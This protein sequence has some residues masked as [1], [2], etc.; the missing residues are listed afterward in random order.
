MRLIQDHAADPTVYSSIPGRE[1]TTA[2]TRGLRER[3]NE[4]VAF[5]GSFAELLGS[6]PVEFPRFWTGAKSDIDVILLAIAAVK[7]SRYCRKSLSGNE[8]STAAGSL[9]PPSTTRLV[10]SSSRG[11]I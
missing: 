3:C 4:D 1:Q 11:R 5:I 6:S 2:W 9:C 7:A 10:A 8:R